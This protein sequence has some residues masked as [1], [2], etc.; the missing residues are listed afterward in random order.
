MLIECPECKG[1]VSDQA[2]ACPHCGHP[3]KPSA[4]EIP[5]AAPTKSH[6]GRNG[7]LITLAIVAVLIFIGSLSSNNQST[8]SDQAT[9]G[10]RL[11]WTKCADNEQLVNNY[12]QWDHVRYH[13]E[14][15]AT[16]EAKYGTPKW[17]WYSFGTFLK[18]NKYISSGVAVAIEPDAQFS[19]GFGALVHSRVICSYDL[20]AQ[21]VISVDVS[22]R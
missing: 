14:Q 11:N 15:E 20:R 19:N 4:R 18:G 12:S 6:T 1:Q 3:T 2:E 7:C 16:D 9:N 21:R 13:C 5:P 8:P 22:P 17:P 10:C